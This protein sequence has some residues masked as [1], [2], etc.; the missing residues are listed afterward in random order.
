VPGG[1]FLLIMISGDF[2]EGAVIVNLCGF[3]V[4][5]CANVSAAAGLAWIIKEKR[6]GTMGSV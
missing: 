4:Y 1:F 3:W 5:G 2:S 6:K